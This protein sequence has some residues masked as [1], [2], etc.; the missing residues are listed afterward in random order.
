MPTL[1]KTRSDRAADFAERVAMP[2]VVAFGLGLV[3]GQISEENRAETATAAVAEA[4]REVARVDAHLKQW[5]QTCGPLLTLPVEN[6]PMVLAPVAG[7]R[8]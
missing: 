5:A 1:F 2:L 7:E 3:V 4:R 6:S 8:P